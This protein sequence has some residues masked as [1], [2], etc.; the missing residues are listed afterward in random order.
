MKMSEVSE[1]RGG[2]D[3]KVDES[4]KSLFWHGQGERDVNLGAYRRATQ[5]GGVD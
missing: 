1:R 5:N 3:E 2:R 4:T